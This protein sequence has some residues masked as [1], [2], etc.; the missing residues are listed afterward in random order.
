MASPFAE[1]SSDALRAL[2]ASLERQAAECRARADLLDARN[3]ATTAHRDR[4]ADLAQLPPLVAQHLATGTPFA[5]AV[6]LIAQ[7]SGAPADQIEALYKRWLFDR[8]TSAAKAR[9]DLVLGLARQG[10]SNV[11]IAKRLEIAPGSVSRILTRVLG[12]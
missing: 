12:R 7:A 4:A 1:L 2:A 5:A 3:R 11:A 8:R 6:Q 10:M 9:E